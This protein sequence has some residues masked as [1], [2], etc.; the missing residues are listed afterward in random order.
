MNR[1]TQLLLFIVVVFLFANVGLFAQKP[2]PKPKAVTSPM[3]FAILND[4]KLIEPVA[5][6][7]NGK[8]VPA[9]TGPSDD[10][11]SKTFVDMYYSPKKVYSI[12]FG[13]K[14]NG[15]ATI[16]KSNIGTECGGNSA[17][18]LSKPATGSLKGLVMAL[19]TNAKL[20]KPGSGLRRRPTPEERTEIESL[21]RAEF[22]KEGTS[23]AAMKMLRYH[24]LTALDLNNDGVAEFVGSYWVAPT[25]DERRILFFIAEK[26]A[27]DKY[28][29]VHQDYKSIKPDHVMSG[30]VKDLDTG[31][32]HELLLDVFDY[33][34]DGTSEIFT[35]AKAFEG[36]NYFVYRK[37]D[38]KWARALE[39]YVYRCAY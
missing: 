15:T 8:L 3:I 24:N 38:G 32:G 27:D 39:N 2:R 14:A 26:G 34:G 18:V 6:V 23:A 5:A 35:I 28:A 22:A 36:N 30:D 25:K 1:I 37:T 13:G 12:I 31:I 10:K 11:A 20:E 4:G 7:E 16:V 19:A 21:V 17:D 29:V 33:D 9:D